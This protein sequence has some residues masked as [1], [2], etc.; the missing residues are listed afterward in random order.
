MLNRSAL[1]SAALNSSAGGIE[2]LILMDSPLGAPA[3]LGFHDFT[4]QV[5]E[6]S[7][8]TRYVMDLT[9]P[10]GLVRLPISSWQATL[11]T[12]SSNYVQ[13]VIPAC[14]PY[15]DTIT[16]AAAFTISRRAQSFDGV[17]I[18][19]EMVS[20]PVES[21]TFD[22]GPQRHTCTMSGY[23][24]GFAEDEEPPEAYNRTLQKVR[25]VSSSNGSLRVRC[26]IDWLLRPG[27]RAIVDGDTFVVGYINYYAIQGDQYMDVGEAA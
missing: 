9:T 14:D 5:V 27:Q 15:V 25:S 11:R 3:V 21:L 19:Y 7:E 6:G 13:C 12:G 2:C 8:G 17:V 23:S 10:A 18:E 26:G 24:T 20:G 16:T 22:P 4:A 1:N